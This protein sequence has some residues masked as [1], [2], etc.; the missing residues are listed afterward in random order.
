MENAYISQLTRTVKMPLKNM[1]V[2]H[3]PKMSKKFGK[4][5]VALHSLISVRNTTMLSM[6]LLWRSIADGDFQYN[7]KQK[8][9]IWFLKFNKPY[10]DYEDELKKSG[11]ILNQ[12][13]RIYIG[14]IKVSDGKGTISSIDLSTLT[15][16]KW[17]NDKIMELSIILS[18]E[19]STWKT[20][21]GSLISPFYIKK[22]SLRENCQWKKGKLCVF[23][24]NR[25]SHWM[26]IIIVVQNKEFEFFDPR[27]SKDIS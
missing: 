4:R 13:M 5:K 9:D 10:V 18:I 22:R 16:N 27:Q 1:N 17:L 2:F 21:S 23:L 25:P 15:G 19:K 8:P 11:S 6:F 7:S 24:I 20:K 26:L 14:K 3:H 12:T